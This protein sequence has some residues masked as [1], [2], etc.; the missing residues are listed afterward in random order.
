MLPKHGMITADQLSFDPDNPRFWLTEP[1]PQTQEDIAAAFKHHSNPET[2][3]KDMADGLLNA[4]PSMLVCRKDGKVVVVDG[5]KRLLAIRLMTEPAFAQ[6]MSDHYPAQRIPR[7]SDELAVHLRNIPVDEF[8][9]WEQAHLFSAYRQSNDRHNWNRIIRANDYRRLSELGNNHESIANWYRLKPEVIE[10]QI[11]SLNIYE[12][13]QEAHPS[14]IKTQYQFSTLSE[15]M[16]MPNIRK[17]LQLGE[18]RQYGN[19][20]RPLNQ[21]ALERSKQLLDFLFGHQPDRGTG[22][23]TPAIQMTDRESMKNLDRIYGNPKAL[24]RMTKWPN[25]TVRE[26]IE[27]MEERPDPYRAIQMVEFIHSEAIR[28]LKKL[29]DERD[30]LIPHPGL[31]H[32]AQTSH[33]I[34]NDHSVQYTVHLKTDQPD[35]HDKVP[36]LM[37][38]KLDFDCIVIMH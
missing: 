16:T 9:T 5:N 7:V 27:W 22:Y 14:R 32:V 6:K 36:A 33:Q 1:K 11:N 29:K 21:E 30:D 26:I 17:H 15:A 20:E 19:R 12:Q 4:P 18:P 38:E 8:E 2:M 35:A 3:M 10:R 25:N 23:R 24:E 13:L 34:F 28:E 37:Q 31:I